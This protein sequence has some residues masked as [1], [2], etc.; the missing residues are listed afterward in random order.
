MS[1]GEEAWWEDRKE[2]KAGYQERVQEKEKE[3]H[4]VSILMTTVLMHQ[5]GIDFQSY[6]VI[7]KKKLKNYNL[8]R[9]NFRNYF[10]KY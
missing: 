7:L 8:I 6:Q 1:P 4:P 9:F 3:L 10:I 5:H 2:C